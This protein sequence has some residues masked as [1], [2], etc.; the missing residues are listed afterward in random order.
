MQVIIKPYE[1][2]YASQCAELEQYLWKDDKRKCYKR[3][4]WMY[5]Q[6][7]NSDA[8]AVIAVNEN[9][10]VIGFRPFVLFSYTFHGEE[11]LVAQIADTVVS[12]KFRR[13][14]I[15]SKMNN[16]ALK[17]LKNRGIRLILDLGPSWPPYFANK[18]VGFEDFATFHSRYYFN[19]SSLISNKILKRNRDNRYSSSYNISIQGIYIVVTHNL[20]DDIAAKVTLLQDSEKIHSSISLQNLNWRKIRPNSNYVYA[21]SLDKENNLTSF[22]MFK[23]QDYYNFHLGLYLFDAIA[24]LK[25]AWSM[26]KKLYKP[27]T[28]AIWDF[29]VDKKQNYAIKALRFWSIPFINKIRNNPPALLRTLQCDDQGNLDW[30]IN[31]LDVR[32]I[33]KWSI[34]KFDLDSF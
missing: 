5:H 8:M 13:M 11:I 2:G 31:G 32:D 23:T 1:Q 12:P 26:F 30:I 29:A 34:T 20:S 19:C 7:P 14:G 6:N 3:L 28:V 22:M 25:L 4:E 17:Y 15:L 27:A 21:Y 18:K 16:F 33:N 9:D 10:E 24:D